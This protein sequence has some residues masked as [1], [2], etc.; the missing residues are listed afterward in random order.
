MKVKIIIFIACLFWLQA[1]AAA[2]LE[3]ADPA[4]AG[5]IPKRLDRVDQALE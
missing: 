4:E 5:F 2:A 1:P 3:I